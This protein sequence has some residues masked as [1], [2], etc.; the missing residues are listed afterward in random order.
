MELLAA[1]PS[2]FD[3]AEI[4]DDFGRAPSAID[5]QRFGLWSRQ[6]ADSGGV[7]LR[8]PAG[9]LAILV[10]LYPARDGHG[11]PGGEVWGAFGAAGRSRPLP[12]IRTAGRLVFEIARDAELRF[13]IAH[14][15]HDGVAGQRIARLF[16]LQ[17]LSLSQFSDTG[18][19]QVWRRSLET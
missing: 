17:L 5:R 12:A 3:V 18:P 1:L 13:L 9:D 4:L 7:A 11:R 19:L 10:G 14:I 6:V 15:R 8:T 16:G 2:V